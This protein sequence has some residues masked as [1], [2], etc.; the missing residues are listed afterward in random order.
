MTVTRNGTCTIDMN[1]AARCDGRLRS[2]RR[3]PTSRR[4]TRE[5]KRSNVRV[6]GR[7]LFRMNIHGT[8]RC[9]RKR[10]YNCNTC[11]KNLL[12]INNANGTKRCNT[13]KFAVNR[14]RGNLHTVRENVVLFRLKISW[15]RY[16]GG[17]SSHNFI[18]RVSK[19]RFPH[20]YLPR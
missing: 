6:S 9:T 8:V 3:S 5:R 17:S 19:S 12:D 14:A 4:P 11:K 15:Y 10:G 1:I 20:L 13:T 7:S 16:R 2:E 18:T